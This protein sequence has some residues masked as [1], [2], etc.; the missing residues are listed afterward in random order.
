MAQRNDVGPG[1]LT[2]LLRSWHRGD[3]AGL[4]RVMPVVYDELRTLAARHLAGERPG[5]TLQTT[6]LVHE[7]YLRLVGLNHPDWKNRAYFFGAVGTIM[8]RILVDHARGRARD[9]RGGG[10]TIVPLEQVPEPVVPAADDTVDVE[11]LDEAL[12]KLASIDAR[13]AHIVELRYFSGMTIEEIAIAIGVSTGTVKRDWTVARAWLF[14][15]LSPS[16]ADASP[17]T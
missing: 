5:H 10:V 9:K 16:G 15:E 8:R 3:Q 2:A 7:A 17:A 13:Q 14:A 11:A 1:E 4:E 6:A 12:D